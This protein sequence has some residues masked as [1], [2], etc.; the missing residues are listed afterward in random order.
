MLREELREVREGIARLDKQFNLPALATQVGMQQVG[1]VKEK[2]S[3]TD[4]GKDIGHFT[5][6]AWRD[7]TVYVVIPRHFL[8]EDYIYELRSN[9]SLLPD[10]HYGAEREGGRLPTGQLSLH[11]DAPQ[12]D[13]VILK[14]QVL[15]PKPDVVHL[16]HAPWT[17]GQRVAAY[18]PL[19]PTHKV[20]EGIVSGEGTEPAN[21]TVYCTMPAP[22]GSC[23]TPVFSLSTEQNTVAFIGVIVGEQLAGDAA[24]TA[25]YDEDALRLAFSSLAKTIEAR[26][27]LSRAA[28]LV[29]ATFLLE[30]L[31]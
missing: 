22:S 14:G 7:T 19:L 4:V 10:L 12:L 24:S 1:M 21:S 16:H 5:L 29:S 27:K 6:L 25:S 20:Y 9:I 23:G 13:V 18:S 8:S 31:P 11:Y 17:M 2:T 15:G 3:P 28:K 26:I 30:Q